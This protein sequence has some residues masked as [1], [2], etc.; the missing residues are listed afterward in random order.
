M[1]NLLI[2]KTFM[3]MLVMLCCGTIS[4]AQKK[5]VFVP[6]TSRQVLYGRVT[7]EAGNP[8]IAQVQVW[9][10]PLTPIVFSYGDSKNKGRTDNLIKMAYT[11]E[12]GFYSLKVPADTIMLII[13]KGPEWSLIKEKFVIKEKE[14]NG[15]EFNVKLKRLYDM[16][17]LGWYAG[18]AHTHTI[19][20]DGY[21]TPSEMAYSMKGVGLSWGILSDHNSDAGNKE[22]MSMKDKNFIP[23]PGCE[24]TTEPSDES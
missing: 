2:K 23:I 5:E 6:N 21:E 3:F 10:Y 20:S 19:H 4:N 16:S 24:I 12:E 8:I 14:F 11:T 22:F 15:I 1:K 17:K 7:D 18:D 9:Y 13:T